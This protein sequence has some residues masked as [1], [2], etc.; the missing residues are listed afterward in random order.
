MNKLNLNSSNNQI[1]EEGAEALGKGLS[2]LR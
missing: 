1:E 2:F